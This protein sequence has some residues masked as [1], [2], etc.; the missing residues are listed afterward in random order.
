MRG[1]NL[2]PRRNTVSVTALRECGISSSTCDR[3]HDMFLWESSTCDM[4]HDMFLWE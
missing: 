3:I 4:I 1:H 2:F